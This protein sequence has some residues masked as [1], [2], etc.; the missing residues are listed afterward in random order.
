MR[1]LFRSISHLCVPFLIVF[2]SVGIASATPIQSAVTTV[3]G[4]PLADFEGF[5]EGTLIANQYAGVTF[6]QDDGGTPMID[7]SPFLFGYS[8]AS[9]VGVLTGDRKSVV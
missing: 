2:A 5:A 1:Q 4:V 6:S 3:G 7:N 9:G 8:A